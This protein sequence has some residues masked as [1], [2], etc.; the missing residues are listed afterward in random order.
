MVSFQV[1]TWKNLTNYFLSVI[2]SLFCRECTEDSHIQ[3]AHEIHESSAY[4][5]YNPWCCGLHT[6][7]AGKMQR[8]VRI[9]NF[10]IFLVLNCCGTTAFP[11]TFH[12][13]A[14]QEKPPEN[15]TT[16]WVW[17]IWH[18]QSIATFML[19]ETQ[20]WTWRTGGDYKCVE[21]WVI[22]AFIWTQRAVI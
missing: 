15:N 13:F 7:A 21:E 12:H 8:L 11:L 6:T 17:F 16:V 10:S 5:C 22:P 20:N 14:W 18:Y 4:L 9:C 3:W 19:T 2:F 1:Y